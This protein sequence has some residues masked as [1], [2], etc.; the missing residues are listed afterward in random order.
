MCLSL[1]ALIKSFSAD[2]FS[3]PFSPQVKGWAYTEG[4][5]LVQ[6]AA[7]VWSIYCP[8]LSPACEIDFAAVLQRTF[9]GALLSARRQRFRLIIRS[10]PACT[11]SS[12]HAYACCLKVIH[13][14]VES[15]QITHAMLAEAW[16]EMWL[17][18]CSMGKGVLAFSFFVAENGCVIC[19]EKVFCPQFVKRWQ[20]DFGGLFEFITAIRHSGL[21][22]LV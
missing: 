4:R 5:P 10:L 9:P 17:L 13:S 20:R 21:F 12:F 14:S 16:R 22:D 6:F 19:L 11:A 1:R 2:C 15:R 3:K 7:L 8:Y 18:A